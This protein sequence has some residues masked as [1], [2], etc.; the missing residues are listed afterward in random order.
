M[1]G[2]RLFLRDPAGMAGMRAARDVGSGGGAVKAGEF[3]QGAFH[4]CYKKLLKFE[5]RTLHG[6]EEMGGGPGREGADPTT[7]GGPGLRLCL[8]F[9]NKK[10]GQDKEAER[11]RETL[12]KW[13]YRPMSAEEEKRCCKK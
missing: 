10:I 5:G 11:V 3:V 2:G 6:T 1:R 7:P 9:F 8:T 4:C 12:K 13:G